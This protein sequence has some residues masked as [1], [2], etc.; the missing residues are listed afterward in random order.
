M[1]YDVKDKCEYHTFLYAGLAHLGRAEVFQTSG[2]GIVT[3][4]PLVHWYVERNTSFS[5]S[6]ITDT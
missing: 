3:P 4:A 1:P 6:I 5:Y 2:E